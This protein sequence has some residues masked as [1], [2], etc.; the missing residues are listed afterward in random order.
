MFGS[1]PPPGATTV[2]GGFKLCGSGNELLGG[3]TFL[4]TGGLLQLPSISVVQSD[5]KWYVSPL[6]VLL[7]SA[8]VN[9]HDITDGSSLFDTPLAPFIYGGLDRNYLTAM[10]KGQTADAID[11]ACLPA[12]T[13]EN[14]VVT[15]IVADPSPDATRRCAETVSFGGAVSES[16]SGSAPAPTVE[17]VVPASTAP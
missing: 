11:P 2:D 4:I 3:L 7:T 13:I 10:V 9:L 16:G 5:G 1:E 8:T 6:G 17:T 15:G 12:L 14:G